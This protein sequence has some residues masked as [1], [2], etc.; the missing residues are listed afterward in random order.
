MRFMSWSLAI[1][2]LVPIS[3][4]AQSATELSQEVREYV[5]VDAPVVAITHALVIDGNAGPVLT[6]Q[7]IVI[8]NGRITAVGPASSVNIP[9]GAE[10]IDASGHSVM[11][12]IIGLHDHTFYGAPPGR[13]A[14]LN[15]SAP[16]LYLGAGVTTIRTAGS[17]STYSELN[18]KHEIDHGRVPGPRMHVTGP[19]ISGPGDSPHRALVSTPEDARRTV[20]YWADEGVTWMKAYVRIRRRE[21]GAAIDEAHKRGLKFTGHL[22]SVTFKEAVELGIDNL[23]HGLLTATDL[24]PEKEPDVC[25][26]GARDRIALTDVNSRAVQEIFQAMIEND[27]ALT[28]TLAVYE[29][30]VPNRG[31]SDQRVFEVMAPEIRDGYMRIRRQID[32]AEQ[33]KVW[34]KFLENAMAF[35]LAF[36]KAGGLLAAGVDPT[37]VGGTLPGFGDQLNFEL[38]IEAGFS[39]GEAVQ[40]MTANGAK[41]LGVDH[42]LGT[43][44][45]GKLADLLLIDGDIAANPSDIRKLTIVFKDGVGYDS[46]KLIESV[47]GQVG[48]R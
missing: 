17:F 19:Y 14:Q 12:G 24:D 23:E 3:T 1:T 39:P 13:R 30:N 35:E 34:G 48:I 32:N 10:V 28:S 16:R 33:M 43:I 38:L 47:K 41:V 7:T 26:G 20:A 42:E 31:A 25:P 2:I 36:Y 4:L 15:F 5:A 18:I 45:P 9:N 8:E 6:D 29:P 22:C 11:P 37:G 21:L 46:A 44:E 40:V 27:V